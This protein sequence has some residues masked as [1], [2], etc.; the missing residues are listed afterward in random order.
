MANLKQKKKEKNRIYITLKI[1]SFDLFN[2][3]F[4]K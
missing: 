2:M 3:M 4:L 1:E